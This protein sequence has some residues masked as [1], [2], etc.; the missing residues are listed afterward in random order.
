VLVGFTWMVV[1]AH[2]PRDVM[3]GA[4]LGSV[5]GIMA[6]FA[7]LLEKARADPDAVLRE[8]GSQLSGLNPAEA[9]SRLKQYGPNEIAQEKR[10]SALKRLHWS[11]CS[12]RWA[13]FLI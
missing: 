1:G 6:T 12:W 11:S 2:Y 7:D 4:V 8:L 10:Q 9:A 5:W 13:C 3:G